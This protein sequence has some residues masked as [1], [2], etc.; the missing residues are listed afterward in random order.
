[1]RDATR[2]DKPVWFSPPR[3]LVGVNVCRLSGKLP[4]SGC[5][6]VEVVSSTGDVQTRSMIYTDYFVRGKEPT[7]VCP[8][9]ER[10]GFLDHLAGLFG[11]DGAQPVTAG[12]AAL[13]PADSRPTSGVVTGGT[14]PPS[15]IF[16]GP[17]GVGKR[18][19]AMALAQALNCLSPK[20]DVVLEDGAGQVTLPADAC[21]ACNACRRIARGTYSDVIAIGPD[22][23]DRNIKVETVREKVIECVGYRPYEARWRMV[24]V[25]DADTMMPFAQ[26][27]LLKTL[28]E[29]PSSSV[30]V[31]VTAHPDDLLPTVRSRCPQV[32][33]ARLSASE[34]AAHLRA[35]HGMTPPEA[36]AAAAASDGS[37]GVALEAGTEAVTAV[38]D[39]ARRLLEQLA[40]PGS[41]RGRLAAAQAIVG[42]TA[43]GYGVGERESVAMHLRVLQTMLRDIGVISTRADGCALA[44]EDLAD[45][46][47]GL[48]P[49]FDHARLVHAFTAVHRAIDAL[50]P[51]RNGSP[52]IVADWV[53]LQI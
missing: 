17:R 51:P 1:M 21:G 13:P 38:R 19:T 14:V 31:L 10:D 4:N 16:S 42:K 35:M 11:K 52:K 18:R 5:D 20:T 46:L 3:N 33:F 27:A 7:E 30:F 50:G 26:N 48:R 40:R 25:D 24:L 53:T 37:I 22:P 44:N 6:S 8:L 15:L 45:V 9:H 43:K 34:I 32:R 12:E 28:E 47:E 36:H 41:L 49:A 2:G 23:D 29:P 39:G